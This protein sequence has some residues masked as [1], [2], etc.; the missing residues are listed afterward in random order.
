M[1]QEGGGALDWA[2]PGPRQPQKPRSPRA[3]KTPEP[4]QIPP[5]SR[6]QVSAIFLWNLVSFD[7]TGV[8]YCSA[9]D[10]GSYRDPVIAEA[11]RAHNE[12]ARA[13]GKSGAGAG[14][15]AAPAA[16]REERELAGA[17]PPAG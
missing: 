16:A 12:A 11:I 8:H 5:Q 14:P 17:P 6:N 3:P 10:E 4:S 1:C 13:R 15:P 2:R 9:S 7:A